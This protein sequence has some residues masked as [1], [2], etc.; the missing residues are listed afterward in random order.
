M[1]GISL[2]ISLLEILEMLVLL[3]VRKYVI[4]KTQIFTLR[5]LFTKNEDPVACASQ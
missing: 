5:L 2:R 4:L 1:S 3:T